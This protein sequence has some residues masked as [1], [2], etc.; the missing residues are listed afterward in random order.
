MGH[1]GG[2]LQIASNVAVILL[3]V[4]FLLLPNGPV[5]TTIRS[6]KIEY[7]ARQTVRAA[8]PQ[9]S[10][11]AMPLESSLEFDVIEFVDYECPFCRRAHEQVRS[12]VGPNQNLSI[13]YVQFPL[14]IHAN[15]EA[16]SRAAICAEDHGVFTEFH[17]AL[18]EIEDLEDAD[19]G[20]LASELAT[21]SPADFKACMESDRTTAALDR[22]RSLARSLSINS[23][24]SFAFRDGLMRGL[25]DIEEFASR[26]AK[27]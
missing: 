3:A 11:L 18:F 19:Y 17:N 4:V 15:A 22:H 14:P 16:A 13:G 10:A 24:P 9:V 21:V 20:G 25:V 2:K 26:A 27:R 23:T 1:S 12:M 8:W 7:D 6:W 5:I